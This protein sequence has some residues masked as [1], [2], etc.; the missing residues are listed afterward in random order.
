MEGSSQF[1]FYKAK[2]IIKIITSSWA[3]FCSHRPTKV[4]MLYVLMVLPTFEFELI[5]VDKLIDDLN[6]NVS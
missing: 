3:T 6:K 1:S 4:G 2:T 5:M